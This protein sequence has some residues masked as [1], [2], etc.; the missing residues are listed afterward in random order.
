MRAYATAGIT[1]VCFVPPAPDLRS[2]R[3]TL[4]ILAPTAATGEVA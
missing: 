3:R 2:S 4:E 1:E